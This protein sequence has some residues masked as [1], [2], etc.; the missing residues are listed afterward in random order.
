M[1]L[2]CLQNSGAGPSLVSKDF[3]LRGWMQFIKPIRFPPLRT[4][5]CQ[6]VK[7]DGILTVFVRIGDS[8]IRTWFEKVEVFNAYVLFWTFFKGWCILQMSKD[9]REVVPWLLSPVVIIATKAVI[10][11][12]Y[13]DVNLLGDSPVSRNNAVLDEMQ[14]CHFPRQ[15]TI[16]THMHGTVV[17][18]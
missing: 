4:G 11:L 7:I 13:T 3:L 12:I 9:K 5:T 8:R 17:V 18:R 2:A 6:V 10:D 14:L 16:P 1:L 15:G